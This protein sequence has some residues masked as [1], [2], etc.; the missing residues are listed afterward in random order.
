MRSQRKKIKPP[1]KREFKERVQKR[2][3]LKREFHKELNINT[4]THS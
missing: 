1:Q 2:N 4:R 3:P